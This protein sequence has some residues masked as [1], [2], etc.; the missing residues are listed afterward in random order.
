MTLKEEQIISKIWGGNA[1]NYFNWTGEKRISKQNLGPKVKNTK[2]LR[3]KRS[4]FLK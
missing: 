4:E 1:L 2:D 3:I